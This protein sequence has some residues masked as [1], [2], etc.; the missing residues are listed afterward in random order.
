[1]V[2]QAKGG[3]SWISV[4]VAVVATAAFL[5]WLATRE[6]PEPV[7]VVEPGDTADA[8]AAAPDAPATVVSPDSMTN[9]AFVRR[10]VGQNIELES[11]PVSMAMGSQF[12]WVD[13]P[14]GQSFLVRMDSAQV[15]SGA[16]PPQSG[17][18]HLVGTLTAKDNAL[19]DA[20]RQNGILESDD[21]RMQAEFGSSYIQARRVEPAAGN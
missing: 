14:N 11:V 21:H 19:L 6:R 8:Q 10:M 2:N 4:V 1:M 9:T 20:W 13:M 3:S 5:G 15:A 17:N 12:F 16:Q 7:A 18:V